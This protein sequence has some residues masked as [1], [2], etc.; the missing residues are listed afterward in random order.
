MYVLYN[1]GDLRRLTFSDVKRPTSTAETGDQPVGA[2]ERLSLEPFQASYCRSPLAW[3]MKAA[4]LTRVT[5]AAK[6][7]EFTSLKLNNK[8]YG[9]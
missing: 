9:P 2:L 6:T 5:K 3:F 1:G 4:R 8:K 7:T